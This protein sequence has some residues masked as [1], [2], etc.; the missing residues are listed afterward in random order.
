MFGNMIFVIILWYGFKDVE[1]DIV[2]N[3]IFVGLF[4]N[5]GEY[6]K[7]FVNILGFNIIVMVVL[8]EFI[9]VVFREVILLIY[10]VNNVGFKSKIVKVI[11]LMLLLNK[12]NLKG[13]F[14]L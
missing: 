2:N 4:Y 12:F 7:G 6:I 11:V 1:L 10:V 8:Y 5:G 3:F 13:K 14:V 9:F